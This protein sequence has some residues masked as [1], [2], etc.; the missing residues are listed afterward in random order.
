[1]IQHNSK[2][3]VPNIVGVVPSMLF[4]LPHISTH[5]EVSPVLA[6]A[7]ADG[8]TL[9]AASHA[10]APA[11]PPGA[12]RCMSHFH[13]FQRVEALRLYRDILRKCREFTWKDQ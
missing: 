11:P 10:H 6:P 5:L 13:P 1:M 2:R 3:A 9:Q 8:G 12:T 7:G 4:E